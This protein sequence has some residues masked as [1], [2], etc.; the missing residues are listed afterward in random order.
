MTGADKS[1]Q[2]DG[3]GWLL[4]LRINEN[5]TFTS[6]NENYGLHCVK[7]NIAS[8][9]TLTSV[10]GGFY[11]YDHF[12]ALEINNQGTIHAKWIKIWVMSSTSVNLGTLEVEAGEVLEINT[13]DSGILSLSANAVLSSV[14]VYSNHETNTMT[15]HTNGY[16]LSC[17]G[18][19]ELGTRG[20]IDLGEGTHTFAD[21]FDGVGTGSDVIPGTSTC[22]FTGADKTI[23]LQ[24]ADS[25]YRA[26]VTGTY[27]LA[28]DI[29]V[30]KRMDVIGAL[31][32]GA[33]SI[34]SPNGLI[35][36]VIDTNYLNQP[37]NRN[38]NDEGVFGNIA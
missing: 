2:Y 28:S 24:A 30:T 32:K 4:S 22:Y 3:Y 13:T 10:T 7:I 33:Y 26:Y 12:G 8:G 1:I 14:D 5:T 17:A 11:T 38:L 25:F 23:Q 34:T 36:E 18:A 9:K 35:Q 27:T 29:E 6:A 19:F 37:I 31:K 16:N 15:L 21:N 20:I